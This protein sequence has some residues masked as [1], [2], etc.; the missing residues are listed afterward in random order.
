MDIKI[1]VYICV[2]NIKTISN[3]FFFIEEEAIIGGEKKSLYSCYE[4]TE[5]FLKNEILLIFL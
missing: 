4:L 3:R 5:L 1:Y 2:H